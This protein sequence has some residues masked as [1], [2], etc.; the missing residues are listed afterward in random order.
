MLTL[1]TALALH[2]LIP[3]EALEPL[4]PAERGHVERIAPGPCGADSAMSL[5]HEADGPRSIGRDLPLDEVRGKRVVVMVKALSRGD[6]PPPSLW[7][8][9]LTG[10]PAVPF[11]HHTVAAAG[12]CQPLSMELDVPPEA[13]QVTVGVQLAQAGVLIVE[14]MKWKVLGEAKPVDW[15]RAPMRADI[16]GVTFNEA[17]LRWGRTWFARG[18]DGTWTSTRGD[19]AREV[20]PRHWELRRGSTLRASFQSTFTGGVLSV[21]GTT[22]YGLFH[23]ELA[24][25]QLT[26]S[27]D[28]QPRKLLAA[29]QRARSVCRRFERPREE[30]FTCELLPGAYSMPQAALALVLGLGVLR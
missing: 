17:A 5:T 11:A 4:D 26:V 10:S 14:P 3:D 1:V 8:E 25:D 7:V 9:L 6:A 2:A 30:H 21:D 23:I 27:E 22:E 16:D 12:H 20:S 24:P 29:P 19:Q 15:T 13:A 28:G 18:P